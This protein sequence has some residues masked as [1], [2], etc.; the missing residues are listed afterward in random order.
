M[1]IEPNVT[2]WSRLRA[3]SSWERSRF[4]VAIRGVDPRSDSAAL[5]TALD[6][7]EVWEHI[8]SGRPA[9]V[10]SYEARLQE[11]SADATWLQVLITGLPPG[12][13]LG[14]T[15]LRRLGGG[16]GEIGSTTISRAAWGTG[17][18]TV[19]KHLCLD[20]AFDVVGFDEV[21]FRTDVRNTRS[22]RAIEKLGAQHVE[23]LIGDM[24]RGDGSLRDT[25]IYRI[26]REGWPDVSDRLRASTSQKLTTTLRSARP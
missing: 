4:G 21:L 9:D 19:A 22:Q 15:A 8:P 6:V 10:V 1:T 3:S 25:V 18:N 12:A 7:P 23:T 5:F 26:S 16:Q 2:G 14:I 24:R 11:R 17:V 13:V 20:L